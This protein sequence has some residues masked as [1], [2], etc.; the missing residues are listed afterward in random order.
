[1]PVVT[2]SYGDT[3]PK[4]TDPTRINVPQI[5]RKLGPY[6]LQRAQTAFGPEGTVG[7]F[8]G[9]F[10]A[11]LYGEP[12]A[13]NADYAE[14]LKRR[15]EL[16]GYAPWMDI[17]NF[18]TSRVDLSVREMR[19]IIHAYDH[20]NARLKKAVDDYVTSFNLPKWEGR[21]CD[22]REVES[23]LKSINDM[24]LHATNSTTYKF[25]EVGG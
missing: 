16:G 8:K 13:L 10:I 23:L 1:M 9:C 21:L 11:M 12:G 2:I 4:P 25:E 17:L 18:A 6:R 20:D 3:T 7:S 19:V 14:W 5:L 15:Y 22:M 24:D